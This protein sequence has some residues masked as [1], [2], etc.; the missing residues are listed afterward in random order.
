MSAGIRPEGF[1]MYMNSVHETATDIVQLATD[2]DQR[3]WIPSMILAM[4]TIAKAQ[5]VETGADF[6]ELMAL[7]GEGLEALTIDFIRAEVSNGN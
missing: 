3:I 2:R 1:D 6:E 7:I 4:G 5:S